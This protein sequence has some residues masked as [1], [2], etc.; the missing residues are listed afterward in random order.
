MINDFAEGVILEITF[1]YSVSGLNSKIS[2][3]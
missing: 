1:N 3:G 2:P